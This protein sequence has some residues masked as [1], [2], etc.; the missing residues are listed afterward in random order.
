VTKNFRR[1][2]IKVSLVFFLLTNW[3]AQAAVN[4]LWAS[5]FLLTRRASHVLKDPRPT[6]E[7]G[8][9]SASNDSALAVLRSSR[10]VDLPAVLTYRDALTEKILTPII[11]SSRIDE[12]PKLL[13]FNPA[14]GWRTNAD[15]AET[16]LWAHVDEIHKI[17]ALYA[18]GDFDFVL[19]S[20]DGKVSGLLDTFFRTSKRPLADLLSQ[21]SNVRTLASTFKISDRDAAMVYLSIND[22]Q[23]RDLLAKGADA[24]RHLDVGADEFAKEYPLFA[25]ID[26]NKIYELEAKALKIGAAGLDTTWSGL[27]QRVTQLDI[28]LRRILVKA[29]LMTSTDESATPMGLFA[30]FLR[31]FHN[32][33]MSTPTLWRNLTIFYFTDVAHTIVGEALSRNVHFL[34]QFDLFMQNF[35]IFALCDGIL[36]WTA[37]KSASTRIERYAIEQGVLQRGTWVGRITQKYIDSPLYKLAARAGDKGTRSYDYGKALLKNGTVM[38]GLGFGVSLVGMT[39]FEEYTDWRKGEERTFRDKFL[40]ALWQASLAGG[41]MFWSSN[42]RYT[43]I[44]HVIAPLI[45][46]TK[47]LSKEEQDLTLFAVSNANAMFGATGYVLLWQNPLSFDDSSN[48][49]FNDPTHENWREQFERVAGGMYDSVFGTQAELISKTHQD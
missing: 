1:R 8:L 24:A 6:L 9:K 11:K 26:F 48:P 45:R 46:G 19:G 20:A 18:K 47:R 16:W 30:K 5:D 12:L 44:G 14:L 28:D 23:Y 38:G 37:Y 2:G 7:R 27:L 42:V 15:V 10:P 31:L 29:R 13:D 33:Q 35:F 43:T 17:Q 25:G 39:G 34:S 36:N 3:S 49:D 21:E 32:K 40:N 22:E 41:W 4:C